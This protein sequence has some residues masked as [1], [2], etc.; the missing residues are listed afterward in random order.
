MKPSPVFDYHEEVKAF[1]ERGLW[2]GRRRFDHCTTIG[3][4]TAQEGLVAGVVYHNYEPDNGVIEL[5]AYSSRRDRADKH[6]VSLIF[7]QYPFLQLGCRL[8]VARHSE[9]NLRARRIWAALGANEHP[10]P[11]LRGPGEAEIIATLRRDVFLN[12]KFMRGNP[13]G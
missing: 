11:E 6:I 10:I 12:S 8:L 4:A 3:F 5:S 9:H 13:D 1:V 7:G 2:D